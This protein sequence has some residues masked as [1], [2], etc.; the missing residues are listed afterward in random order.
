M[1]YCTLDDILEEILEE[2]LIQVTD[3]NGDFGGVNTDG[4]ASAISRAEAIIDAH[5]GSR[6]SLP[7]EDPVPGIIRELTVDLSI[8]TM[9][10]RIEQLPK[11]RE[12]RYRD[13]MGW[14]IKFR[15]KGGSLG[16]TTEE[17]RSQTL[18]IYE[19]PDQDFTDEV[20]EMY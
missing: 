5:I 17:Y 3:P 1:A 14:L 11:Y 19:V 8:Y 16:A 10:T 18:P 15:D 12:R 9:F 6:V 2:T 4:V 20:W 7:L 13:A